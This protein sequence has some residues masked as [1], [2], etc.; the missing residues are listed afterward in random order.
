MSRAPLTCMRHRSSARV[1]SSFGWPHRSWRPR[2]RRAQAHR[3]KQP[4]PQAPRQARARPKSTPP[5]DARTFHGP[6]SPDTIR[7]R[8]VGGAAI[9]NYVPPTKSDDGRSARRCGTQTIDE[10]GGEAQARNRK[11]AAERRWETVD[12]QNEKRQALQAGGFDV[13][14]DGR[15][16]R[17]KPLGGKSARKGRKTFADKRPLLWRGKRERSRRVNGKGPSGSRH[18]C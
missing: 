10:A 13:T 1:H 3:R 17:R 9:L 18:D 6:R 5:V 12:G 7:R 2:Q 15:G 4:L 11:A 16:I 14:S 8:S